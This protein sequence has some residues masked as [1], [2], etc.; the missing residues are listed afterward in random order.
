MQ[1]TIFELEEFLRGSAVTCYTVR[2][3]K[4]NWSL[5]DQFLN[6]FTDPEDPMFIP[7]FQ[8][9]IEDLVHLVEF[10][11]E[12]GMGRFILRQENSAHALP[13]KK[14]FGQ[15]AR[16]LMRLPTYSL[17]WYCM[18]WPPNILILFGGGIKRSQRNEDSPGVYSAFMLADRITKQID[19]M[20]VEGS[21]AEH[22]GTLVG[23][24]YFFT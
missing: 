11:A 15:G 18:V 21:L 4:Q 17:R 5:A 8:D 13:P 1:G 6:S 16:H 14:I 22:N 23:D 24:L 12:N 19:Q 9:E 3:A 20:I 10:I 7:G 2:S